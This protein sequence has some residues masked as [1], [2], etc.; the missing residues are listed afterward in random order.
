VQSKSCLTQVGSLVLS[1]LFG[2]ILLEIP[3]QMKCRIRDRIS[4]AQSANVVLTFR[5]SAGNLIVSVGTSGKTPI[6]I[7]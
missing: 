2:L 4:V 7:H 3:R 6:S 1:T 5:I